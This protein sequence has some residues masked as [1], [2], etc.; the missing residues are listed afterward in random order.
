MFLLL[1]VYQIG[2]IITEYKK[3]GRSI[4]KLEFEFKKRI[5]F[6]DARFECLYFMNGYTGN[7]MKTG[8][9]AETQINQI[10]SEPSCYYITNDL[11]SGLLHISKMISTSEDIDVIKS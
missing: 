10:T 1:I 11:I 6:F 9:C 5:K 8:G 7:F 2:Y 3:L 4:Q